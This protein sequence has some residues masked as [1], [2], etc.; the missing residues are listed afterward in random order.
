VL[1]VTELLQRL[2]NG[3]VNERKPRRI[4]SENRLHRKSARNR[5]GGTKKKKGRRKK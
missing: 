2:G 1:F 4:Q 5:K 3:H